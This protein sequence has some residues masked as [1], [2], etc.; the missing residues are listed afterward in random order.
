MLLMSETKLLEVNIRYVE[1]VNRFQA[2]SSQ[3]NVKVKDV[4]VQYSFKRSDTRCVHFEYTYCTSMTSAGEDAAE[5]LHNWENSRD[6][7]ISRI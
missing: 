6:E 2:P 4:H 7:M 3:M 5:R 1:Y